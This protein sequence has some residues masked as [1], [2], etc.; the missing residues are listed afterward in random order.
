MR[1]QPPRKAALGPQDPAEARAWK[2]ARAWLLALAGADPQAMAKQTS[3]PLTF[4]PLGLKR[5]CVRAAHDAAE[6]AAWVA[7]LTKARSPILSELA[8]AGEEDLMWQARP[9]PKLVALGKGLPKGQWTQAYVN[10]DGV[11]FLFRLLVVDG[12]DGQP[13]VAAFLVRA[14]FDQG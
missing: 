13:R 5:S 3:F 11:T 7:C 10:G 2:V 6:L 14:S 1:A 12:D 8:A 4:Q 9:D